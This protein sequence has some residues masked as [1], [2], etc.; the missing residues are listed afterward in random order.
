[1][2]ETLALKREQRIRHV[3]AYSTVQAQPTWIHMRKNTTS[4]W[5]A[6]THH[7]VQQ[8]RQCASHLAKN[9]ARRLPEYTQKCYS[10]RAKIK[11]VNPPHLICSTNPTA[12]SLRGHR[13]EVPP[14]D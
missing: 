2:S 4:F 12:V 3:W 9:Q 8:G 6:S 1:M 14:T 7:E 5:R 11:R 10:I 13:R